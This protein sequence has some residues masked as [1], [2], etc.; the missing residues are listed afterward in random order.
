MTDDDKKTAIT[1]IR[2]ECEV[3]TVEKF[4]ASEVA[5]RQAVTPSCVE[6]QAANRVRDEEV[7]KFLKDTR[8]VRGDSRIVSETL[9]ISV[10]GPVGETSTIAYRDNSKFRVEYIYGTDLCGGRGTEVELLLPISSIPVQYRRRR[11]RSCGPSDPI[12]IGYTVLPGENIVVRV[13][14]LSDCEFFGAIY[15]KKVV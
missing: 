11:I 7:L 12:A 10:R 9:P 4:D 15:G 2:D 8:P 1:L 6:A 14:F 3:N 5:E 13:K